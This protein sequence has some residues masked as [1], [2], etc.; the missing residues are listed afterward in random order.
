MTCIVALKSP[1]G[2]VLGSDSRASCW[3]YVTISGKKIGK[4]TLGEEEVMWGVTGNIRAV[5]VLETQVK[6]PHRND[7]SHEEYVFEVVEAIERAF[8]TNNVNEKEN[9]VSQSQSNLI[10]VYE[11]RIYE[12]Y[13][14]FAYVE[15]SLPYTCSGSG[16]E[17]AYGFLLSEALEENPVDRVTE[18]ISSAAKIIV[19]VDDNVDILTSWED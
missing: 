18:A 3:S 19:S 9:G 4:L 5:N 12:V 14:D 8:N 11:D 6:L 10:L 2:V 1:K 15:P 13:S 16:A 7:L 17:V